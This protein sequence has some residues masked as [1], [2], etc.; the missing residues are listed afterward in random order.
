MN[1]IFII[2]SILTALIGCTDSTEVE[3]YEYS[4]A[5]APVKEV[6]P[7]ATETVWSVYDP[8]PDHLWN[9]VFRQFF[10]RTTKDGK[11]YGA[12][13]LDPLLW[14]DTTYLLQGNSHEQALQVL[15]EFLT[16]YAEN[17]IRDS[18]RRAMFQR[19]MWA[20]F[21]W[22]SF[23]SDPYPSQR[24]A[25]KLR[26]AQIIKRVAL[27]KDEILSF[28]DNYQ[29]AVDSNV[30][31]SNYQAEYPQEAFLPSDLFQPNSAW[32]PMGREGGPIAMAHTNSPP[33]L[34]RS[35]FLVF[36]R[37]PDGRSATLDFIN[38]LNMEPQPL[39]VSGSDVAL[40]RRMLLIDDQGNLVLSP[41]VETVQIRHFNP[42]QTFYEFELDRERLLKGH[43]DTFNLKTDLLMLFFSHGDVFE[44]QNI[45]SFE[46]T[47]PDICKAC[48]VN[49]PAVFDRGNIQG[50]LSYSRANFPL[51][52]NRQPVLSETT[53]ENEAQIVTQWKINHNTWRSLEAFWNETS[54]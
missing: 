13:E 9:R 20:V 35:V 23:Q 1:R 7:A 26:L 48:H 53:W 2:L 4:S 36:V 50:I 6:H 16:T 27:T 31:P 54:P 17:L 33:F 32:V 38:G 18:L 49:N 46:A 29:L 11:E 45:S 40:V 21:D 44:F 41:L 8:D 12:D 34:G 14:F 22:L 19:D 5:T 24:Q 47:I 25:L 28:P 51:L 43:T 52:D 37:S 15:D 10:R 42:G 3:Q 30:F 39:L